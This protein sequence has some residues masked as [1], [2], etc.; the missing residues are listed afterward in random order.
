MF[1]RMRRVLGIGA[2]SALSWNHSS[3]SDDFSSQADDFVFAPPE[4]KCDQC[5]E[6]KGYFRDGEC[7]KCKRFTGGSH[8]GFTK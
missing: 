1:G 5:G 6:K 3:E 8:F 2:F 4:F 7:P